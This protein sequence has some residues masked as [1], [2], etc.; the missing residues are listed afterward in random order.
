M[1][2][3]TS[4]PLLALA[5]GLAILA[6]LLVGWVPRYWPNTVV[7]VAVSLVALLWAITAKEIS[8]PPQTILVLPLT[9]WGLVQ[10][11]FQTTVIS[12]TTQRA[13]VLWFMCLVAFILGSQLLRGSRNRRMFLDLMLGAAIVFAVAAI[14]QAFS[15]P[16]KV[17]GLFP[18]EDSVVGTLFYKNHFAVLMELTAPVALWKVLNGKLVAGGV[19]FALIFAATVTSASR[20]GTIIV[21]GELVVFLLVSILG[22]RLKLQT[23]L[24][25]VAVLMVMAATASA[26]VGTEVLWDR[27][28]EKNPYLLRSRF[29]ESTF[30]MV[31]EHP[32]LGYGMGTWRTV[33]PRFATL[34]MGVIVNEAHNDWAQWAA[35]GGLPF[36]ALML[37]LVAW[38]AIPAVSSVWGLGLVAVMVHAW[39]DYPTRQLSLQLWWFA[40]AGAIS[41]AGRDV[42]A[43]KN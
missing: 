40:L 5:L 42:D 19:C 28:Q 39:V 15:K 23:G 26:V 37:A 10:V 11:A 41:Q 20:A 21:L 25:M 13:S 17:F 1:K 7:T 31:P 43:R 9:V 34:D 8:L 35:E 2:T 29:A 18:A 14:L 16:V 22:R 6:G 33:Y 27:M 12:S 30:R 36:V 32:W 24:A 38:L 3:R 4:P